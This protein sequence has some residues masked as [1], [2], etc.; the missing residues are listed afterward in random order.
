MVPEVVV[1]QL[2]PKEDKVKWRKRVKPKENVS[3]RCLGKD[4]GLL[5]AFGP[6][7][8]QTYW[9]HS[10]VNFKFYKDLTVGCDALKRLTFSTRQSWEI[11]C[12]LYYWHWPRHYKRS[13]RDGTKLFVKGE[14]LPRQFKRQMWSSDPIHKEK[15]AEKL[16]KV[17]TQNYILPGE[18]NSLTGFFT[19]PKGTDDIKIVYGAT[20]CGLNNA[21]W[22]PNFFLPT[23]NLVL[24][25]AN[26]DSW[27][28]D[29]KLGEMFLNYFL[30]EDL[31][32]YAGVGVREIGGAQRECWERALM[33]F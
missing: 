15:M 27:L 7:G 13:I 23:I 12:T 14:V 2:E 30:D 1:Y 20:A 18:V 25:G 4:V 19:A 17:R 29:I 6:R 11:C 33:S 16:G 10:W 31:R 26:K 22:S 21:L 32:K 5:W 3:E 28:S 24:R 8:R 9:V